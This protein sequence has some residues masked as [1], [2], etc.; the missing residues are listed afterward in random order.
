[1]STGVSSRSALV[2]A[3]AGLLC[4]CAQT[5][6]LFSRR[7]TVGSLKTSVSQLEFENDQLKKQVA[8]LETKNRETENQLVDE[9][10]RNGD[11]TARLDDARHELSKRGLDLDDDRA[12]A[13]K[14][15]ESS[16][17]PST[18]RRASR[19]SRS[20]RKPPVARIPGRS[21]EDSDD[22]GPFDLP[23][24]TGD[25]GAQSRNDPFLDRWLPI[26]QGTS[27]SPKQVR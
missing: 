25:P 24:S 19:P 10:S 15:D 1:M 21:D 23:K 6:E 20:K 13:S 12:S 7:T 8:K 3:A 4:G 9:E 17:T 14:S 16:D 26:A 11:L 22:D 5:D 18:T 2:L 27:S